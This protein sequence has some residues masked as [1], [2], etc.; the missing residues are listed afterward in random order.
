MSASDAV[1]RTNN[2]NPV[3]DSEL[4]KDVLSEPYR[5][6]YP[7][8]TH[9]TDHAVRQIKGFCAQAI[10]FFPEIRLVARPFASTNAN[11]DINTEGEKY[12][13]RQPTQLGI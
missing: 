5:P 1:G 4:K 8:L 9:E 13:Q 2:E 10:D 6:D 3:G 7:L 11:H 12:S